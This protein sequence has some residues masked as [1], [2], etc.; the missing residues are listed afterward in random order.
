MSSLTMLQIILFCLLA[1]VL[2][3]LLYI[4]YHF[5]ALEKKAGAEPVA[6]EAKQATFLEKIGLSLGWIYTAI[7][8]TIITALYVV[9]LLLKGGPYEGHFME[10]LNIIIR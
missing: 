3:M 1:A 6:D 4:S 9:Y 2:I 5:Q 10:W 7:V 8:I